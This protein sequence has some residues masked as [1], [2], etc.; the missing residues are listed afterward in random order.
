MTIRDVINRMA[1]YP[2]GTMVLT[3]RPKQ[4]EVGQR[5]MVIPTMYCC[6]CKI[7]M[8]Y[9]RESGH[10]LPRDITRVTYTCGQCGAVTK[11]DNGPQDAA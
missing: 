5:A 9:R 10:G 6:D 2:A 1:Q 8:P 7:V 4:R 11:M 3:P